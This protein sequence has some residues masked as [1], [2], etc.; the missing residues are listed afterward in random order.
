[1]SVFS[2]AARPWAARSL[3]LAGAFLAFAAGNAPAKADDTAAWFGTAFKGTNLGL[4]AGVMHLG[5]GSRAEKRATRRSRSGTQV[6]SLG[7]AY[8]PTTV[9]ESEEPQVAAQPKSR[10]RTRVA[11]L[12]TDTPPATAPAARRAQ[13]AAGKRAAR[14]VRVASLGGTIPTMPSMGPSLSGH[15]IRW[16]A[17]S[18]C[19]NSGLR[20]VV[21]SVAANFGP[22]TVNSTC[23]NRRHNARVGGAKRSHHLTGNAVD[24]RVR[25]NWRAV[26][27]FLRSNGVVGGVKHYGRGLFHIDTGPRRTW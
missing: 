10:R 18:G 8:A 13:R 14:K 26:W 12:G 16:V 20:S 3:L 27:A 15:A 11:S 9:V 7:G 5:A 19:L 6:A 21:A 1:M 2:G 24:F 17:S 25:G 22:V 23:R 4:S